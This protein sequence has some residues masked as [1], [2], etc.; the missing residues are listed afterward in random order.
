MAPPQPLGLGPKR[1]STPGAVCTY[2]APIFH[3]PNPSLTQPPP[4]PSVLMRDSPGLRPGP[5]SCLGVLTL[6]GSAMLSPQTEAVPVPSFRGCQRHFRTASHPPHR[7]ASPS[8]QRRDAPVVHVSCPHTNEPCL[9]T[10]RQAVLCSPRARRS[11]RDCPQPPAQLLLFEIPAPFPFAPDCPSNRLAITAAQPSFNPPLAPFQSPAP[12]FVTMHGTCP[13]L[14]PTA[15][16]RSL[17]AQLCM[18]QRAHRCTES[19][20][21]LGARPLTTPRALGRTSWSVVRRQCGACLF[22]CQVA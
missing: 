4:P 22:G 21:A 18:P 8:A 15:R 12:A 19:S 6:V 3:V 10:L 13:L 14:Q 5:H 2:Q 9:L 20:S 11:L 16:T 17:S 7:S 1:L